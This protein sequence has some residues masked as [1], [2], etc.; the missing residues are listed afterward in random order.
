MRHETMLYPFDTKSTTF[1]RHQTFPLRFGWLTKGFQALLKNPALF[2]DDKA[3][4]TLGVGKNMVEAIQYWL[5]V[6]GMIQRRNEG[7]FEQSERGRIVLG[8]TGDPWL[9]DEVTLWLLHWWIASNSRMATSFYWFFNEATMPQFQE[10]DL[11]TVLTHFTEQRLTK[12]P[13]AS[14]LKSDISTLL[15]MYS[16]S[17][18]K[19]AVQ[20]EDQLDSPLSQLHLIEMQSGRHYQSLRQWRS[21]LPELVLGIAIIERFEAEPNIEALPIRELLYGGSGW[22]APGALFRMSEE[23][24]MYKLERFLTAQSDLFELRDTAGLHQLYRKY[25]ASQEIAKKSSI[26]LLEHHYQQQGG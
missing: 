26:M 12:P 13:S 10:H 15:R 22:P 7:G 20:A 1:G 9:E 16:V 23:G 25:S 2:Y 4:V 18:T 8:E 17:E 6:T 24:F 21:E 3:V 11:R 5:E 19:G 14:T